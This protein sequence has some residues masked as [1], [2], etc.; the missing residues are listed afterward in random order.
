M[1]AAGTPIKFLS[2]EYYQYNGYNGW[3]EIEFYGVEDP[4]MMNQLVRKSGENIHENQNYEKASVFLASLDM[5]KEKKKSPVIQILNRGWGD[6][7]T[8]V[9]VMLDAP[10]QVLIVI[11][12]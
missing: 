6:E 5:A 12:H 3:T 1:I 2:T 8:A 9:T 4:G 7:S 11:K 10:T